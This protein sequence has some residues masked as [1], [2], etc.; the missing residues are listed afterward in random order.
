[1]LSLS[2]GEA[3]E[4]DPVPNPHGKVL[5]AGY[6]TDGTLLVRAGNGFLSAWNVTS[7]ALLAHSK[8]RADL[9][10]AGHLAESDLP[11]ITSDSIP[12]I[13]QR[14]I[15]MS[16]HGHSRMDFGA[17]RSVALSPC[18]ER[19]LVAS[20]GGTTTLW[21]TET[22]SPV[23]DVEH[24]VRMPMRVAFAPS[25]LR[26]AILG[27]PAQVTIATANHGKSPMQA[28][29]KRTALTRTRDRVDAAFVEH[30]READVR[31]AV[32]T[33]DLAPIDAEATEA[34]IE[35]RRDEPRRFHDE[36]FGIAFSPRRSEAQYLHALALI[37]E[38]LKFDPDAL[39]ALCL[40]GALSVRVRDLV[41]AGAAFDRASELVSSQGIESLSA[42]SLGH[43]AVY[44]SKLGD[45]ELADRLM[46]ELKSRGEPSGRPPNVNAVKFFIA[47]DRALKND[48]R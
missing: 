33:D 27:A 46:A 11:R 41:A 5:T 26:L 7:G 9:V 17:D 2:T 14:S 20:L 28:L 19:L 34:W 24:R 44:L 25:G 42:T 3:V 12:S 1:M 23:Y 13:V 39:D 47:V 18:G 21:D 45:D 43:W 36:A 10:S 37:R 30:V 6:G 40:E 29:A 8:Q 22:V 4:L 38:Y 16:D 31:K 15:E 48:R 35:S 32:L